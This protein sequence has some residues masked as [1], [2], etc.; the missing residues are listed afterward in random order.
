M[1]PRFNLVRFYF[2][3]HAITFSY[4]EKLKDKKNNDVLACTHSDSA[5]SSNTNPQ[6]YFKWESYG[7]EP[8]LW[9]TF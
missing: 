8:T 5:V 1:K 4:S 6:D 7:V 9:K 3:C 2:F